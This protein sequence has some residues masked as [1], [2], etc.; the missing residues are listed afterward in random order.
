MDYDALLELSCEIG[1]RLMQ[2]GAEIYRVEESI[3]RILEAYEPQSAEVFAIPNCIITTLVTPEGKTLT[4]MRRMPSHGTD[5]DRLEQYNALCRASCA[6]KHCPQ[7]GAGH[8]LP[9]LMKRLKATEGKK[10]SYSGWQIM[11]AYFTATAFFSLFFGGTWRDALCAGIC[12]IAIWAAVDFMAKRGTNLF[13][14]TAASAAVSAVI[15]LGLTAL[16]F[17]QNI[18]RITIGALMMLVPGVAI[19]NAMREIMGGDMVAGL[20]RVAEGV[21]IATAIALGTGVAMSL[22]R[23]LWGG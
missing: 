7:R 23:F 10:R 15:A 11:L 20:S 22:S 16:G 6:A 12:G 18:D 2:S 9:E 13:F 3:R 17:G 1:F 14:R 4:R 21:L 19:T 5:V 8:D